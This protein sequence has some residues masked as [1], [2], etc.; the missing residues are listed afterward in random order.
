[1]TALRAWAKRRLPPGIQAALAGGGEFWTQRLYRPAHLTAWVSSGLGPGPDRLPQRHEARQRLLGWLCRAQDVCGG[2]GVA[3]WYALAG[4]W[5]AAYPETT[6]YIIPTVLEAASRTGSLADLTRA[7]RMAEWEVTVQLPEGGW[8]GGLV[9]DPPVP[10]VFNTGQVLQGLLAAHAAFNDPAFAAAAERGA[11][12]LL[13]VQDPDGAWRRHDYQDTPHAYATRVAWPLAVLAEQTGD[14]RLRQAAVR[15]LDWTLGQQAPDGWFACSGFAPEEAAF[16]HTI[17]YTLE[18]LIEAAA[19]LGDERY[20]QAAQRAAEALLLTF[21][22][23]R[24]L[25]GTYGPGWTGDFRFACVTGEA[26]MGR[27]WARLFD[28]TG[29]ARYLNAA[30]KITDQV[31]AR[32]AWGSRHPGIQ[33][34]VPGSAPLWGPYMRFRFP[35]WAVKFTLDA[36]LAEERSLGRLVRAGEAARPTAGDGDG[37]RRAT[38]AA[39][40]SGGGACGS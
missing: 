4:G 12:W 28:L 19:V 18:G 24:R 29:D 6:G 34:G 35:S 2:G 39:G 7:R 22:R 25:A 9:T 37:G 10:I 36:L 38:A 33:A 11:G 5:S 21:E 32:I 13:S 31:L 16:T 8:Q 30:L 40:L 23:R 14:R 27:V 26:Q 15:N 17:A 20:H 3:G 1:M